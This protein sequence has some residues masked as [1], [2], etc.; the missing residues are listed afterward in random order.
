I[1]APRQSPATLTTL[2][3]GAWRVKKNVNTPEVSADLDLLKSYKWPKRL[4]L[5][6]RNHALEEC[7]IDEIDPEGQQVL[8]ATCL[9]AVRELL[10]VRM[11]GLGRKFQEPHDVVVK[12]ELEDLLKEYGNLKGHRYS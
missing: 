1:I 11:T 12:D 10:S 5:Q 4:I 3:C 2:A 8:S 9:E 6:F 7:T